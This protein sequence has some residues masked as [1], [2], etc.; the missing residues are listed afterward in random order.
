MSEYRGSWQELFPNAGD[1]CEVMGTRL[2]FHGE[3]STA[4]WEVVD[5]AEDRLVL[6]TPARLPLVLERTMQLDPDHAVLLIEE[7]VTN[8][9]PLRVPFIWGH[10]PAFAVTESSVLDI[11]AGRVEASNAFTDA[12][13]DI[14]PGSTSAWPTLPGRD[15]RPIDLRQPVLP[16]R[17]HRLLWL[18]EV[19]GGWAAIRDPRSG[20]GV[21]LAWDRTTFPHAWLWQEIGTPGMPWF[22]RSAI[23]A[24]EPQMSW[25]SAGLA[26]AIER[27]QAR[28]L[29]PGGNHETWITCAVFAATDRAVSEVTR[30][31]EVQEVW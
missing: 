17:A 4:R 8:E 28:W 31:G 3:V 23:T 13:G 24:I 12:D 15:G 9:S 21:A 20:A 1:A 6:R 26:A 22:G 18:P 16:G 27:G 5:R 7:Q 19:S 11:P 30:A 25:P 29:E 10:H 2:P 14:E